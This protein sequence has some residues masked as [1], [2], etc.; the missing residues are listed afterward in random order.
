M[1]NEPVTGA[2]GAGAS[3]SWDAVVIGAG[4]AGSIAA[5]MLARSGLR[6]LLVEKS[7]FPRVKVC[8]CCL[9]DGALG[10]LDS[11]GLGDV[12]RGLPG[13]RLDSLVVTCGGREA[14]LRTR[15][16]LAVGRA[17][18]DAALVSR[19]VAEGV[20]F[21][22]GCS[23][24]VGGFAEGVREVV[25]T[26]GSR[27]ACVRAGMVV[28]ADGLAGGSLRGVEGMESVERAGSRI[29]LG[30]IVPVGVWAPKPGVIHMACA[31]GGYVG[32][33]D[34]GDGTQAI[35]A[36]VD[37]DLIRERGGPGAAVMNVW[38]EAGISA[39]AAMSEIDWRGT[40]RLTRRRA[41]VEAEGLLVIG[42]ASGYVEPFTG[43][44]MSWA[45]WSGLAAAGIAGARVRGSDVRGAWGAAMKKGLAWRR[46]R[47]R[48][49]AGVLRS[50]RLVSLGVGIASAWPWL[51]S[52]VCGRFG[53]P[54]P[55][56]LAG[57]G[58]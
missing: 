40:A 24:A 18:M 2:E 57:G 13:R 39:P 51:G 6:V 47:C 43:E 37:A 33:V 41:R 49:A 22:S 29:G 45:I 1:R 5:T 25:L 30:V 16:G 55:A 17:A 56:R 10:L 53:A 19:A 4:P 3:G 8:G 42:D 14:R 15:P 12:V 52:N 23:A 31:R 44:G 26:E 20:E 36:A 7:A 34:L 38:R 28:C 21:R 9:N 48:I 35:G 50:P 46:A 32:R 27:R 11:V 54:W 58:S